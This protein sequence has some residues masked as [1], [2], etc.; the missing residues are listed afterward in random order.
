MPNPTSLHSYDL[1]QDFPGVDSNQ[2]L[3]VLIWRRAEKMGSISKETQYYQFT[4]I[5]FFENFLGVD[6][7]RPIR[8]LIWR[9]AGRR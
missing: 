7:N 2:T 1:L 4:I 9:R 5:V 3:H 8:V 6:N